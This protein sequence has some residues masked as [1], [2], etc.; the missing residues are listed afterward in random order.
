MIFSVPVLD[1]IIPARLSP[2]VI[3]GFHGFDSCGRLDLLLVIRI[4]NSESVM[5]SNSPLHNA[6]FG[7]VS[8]NKQADYRILRF[9]V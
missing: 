7:S 2:L 9:I 6:A 3:M 5:M 8:Y 1:F 4:S